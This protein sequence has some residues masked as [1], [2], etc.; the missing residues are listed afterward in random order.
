MGGRGL[1]GVMVGREHQLSRSVSFMSDSLANGFGRSLFIWGRAG[2]GKTRM[3]NEIER[4]LSRTGFLCVRGEDSVGSSPFRR[5][6]AGWF[7]TGSGG[8][9]QAEAESF[10]SVLEGML[11]NL[12]IS[13]SGMHDELKKAAPWLRCFLGIGDWKSELPEDL[14]AVQRKN[15]VGRAVSVFFRS[16]AAISPLVVVTEDIHRFSGDDLDLTCSIARQISSSP[17]CLVLTGRPHEMKR[18]SGLE[19]LESSSSSETLRLRGL[20]RSEL[21]VFVR[22]HGC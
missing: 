1:T 16:V 13:S 8:G 12:S 20:S 18:H 22:L 14:E 3:V 9:E 6:I 21:E 7:G 2:L 19:E 4:S 10:E 5:T 17:L 15:L 11:L